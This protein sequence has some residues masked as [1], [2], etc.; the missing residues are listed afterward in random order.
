MAVQKHPARFDAEDRRVGHRRHE[1]L[2]M[3]SATVLK[4]SA[5]CKWANSLR[6]TAAMPVEARL[7]SMSFTFAEDKWLINH[8]AI[9][10]LIAVDLAPQS[11]KCIHLWLFLAWRAGL[12]PYFHPTSVHFFSTEGLNGWAS[13]ASCLLPRLPLI[14]WVWC[15]MSCS[16][17]TCPLVRGL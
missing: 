10:H 15:E 11:P 9:Y 12:S 17:L 2:W 8:V 16:T 13:P 4:G 7:L 14:I 5:S 1:T 6:P 3:L